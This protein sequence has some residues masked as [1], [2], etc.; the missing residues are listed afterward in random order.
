MAQVLC[1]R[2]MGE[3]AFAPIYPEAADEISALF[4]SDDLGVQMRMRGFFV[5]RARV[6]K[7]SSLRRNRGM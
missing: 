5:V 2:L 1:E 6:G 7:S 4:L 3:S